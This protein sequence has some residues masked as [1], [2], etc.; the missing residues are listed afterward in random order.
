MLGACANTR[1]A[2]VHEKKL[3][4]VNM[5][6]QEKHKDLRGVVSEAVY[7]GQLNTG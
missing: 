6:Q 1:G 5:A 2:R 4:Q 3:T 7:L